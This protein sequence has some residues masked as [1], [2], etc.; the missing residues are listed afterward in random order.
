MRINSFEPGPTSV[1][2]RL[3][4]GCTSL[5]LLE[6]GKSEPGTEVAKAPVKSGIKVKVDSG[7]GNAR[8]VSCP[9]GLEGITPNPFW[10]IAQEGTGMSRSQDLIHANQ[11]RTQEKQ[12][13]CHP[14]EHPSSRKD[15]LDKALL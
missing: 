3:Q 11:S 2:E 4:Q 13:L 9:L 10:N 6:A 15:F 8:S 14:L 1:V 7:Q 12:E 5:T